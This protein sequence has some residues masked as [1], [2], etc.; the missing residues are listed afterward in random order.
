MDLLLIR[1]PARKQ[2][3]RRFSSAA[4]E[5]FAIIWRRAVDLDVLRRAAS[6][7]IRRGATDWTPVIAQQQIA[8]FRCWL[9]TRPLGK[10]DYDFFHKT[11]IDENLRALA[12]ACASDDHL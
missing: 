2:K 12:L 9:I 8:C 4:I 5:K 7:V 11:L 10:H 3:L 1:P 6:Y